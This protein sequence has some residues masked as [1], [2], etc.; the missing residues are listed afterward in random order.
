MLSKT[1]GDSIFVNILGDNTFSIM[2]YHLFGFFFTN[3]LILFVNKYTLFLGE[4]DFALFIDK[5]RN[6]IYGSGVISWIYL[7]ISVVVS[8]FIKYIIE[9]VKEYLYNL[10]ERI[11]MLVN[12]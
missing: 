2:T 6:S 10:K 12:K 3:I 8:L 11:T 5:P 4:L 7:I 9:F 1:T